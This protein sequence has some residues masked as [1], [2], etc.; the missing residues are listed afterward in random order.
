MRLPT[1][2]TQRSN[3]EV[4]RGLIGDRTGWKSAKAAAYPHQMN[5]VLAKACKLF[6]DKQGTNYFKLQVP[7]KWITN[8]ITGT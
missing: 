5:Q 2:H 1:Q 6:A 4:A 8:P 7:M 3:K